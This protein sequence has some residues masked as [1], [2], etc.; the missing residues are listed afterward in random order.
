M[1]Y[2]GPPWTRTAAVRAFRGVLEATRST[3][4]RA[5]F[6]TLTTKEAQQ[7]IGLCTLQNLDR[8]S[9]ADRAGCDARAAGRE[10]GLATE[11]LI[12]VI[13][14]AFATLPVDE[15]WVRFAIDHV[16]CERLALS[17]GL[18]RYA[19]A[20][21]ED[22]AANCGA[23]RPAAAPGGPERA[24][25]ALL[26]CPRRSFP[27]RLAPEYRRAAGFPLHR[28]DIQNDGCDRFPGAARTQCPPAPRAGRGTGAGARRERHRSRAA[29]RAARRRHAAPG[30][31]ARRAADDLLPD[32]EARPAKPTKT[33]RTRRRRT[34]KR[35]AERARRSVEVPV[36]CHRLRRTGGRNASARRVALGGVGFLC[37]V[38]AS[39][40]LALSPQEADQ[41]LHRADERQ[42]R[43]PGTVQHVSAA[44]R[45][46]SPRRSRSPQQQFLQYLQGWQSAYA[47]NYAQAIPPLE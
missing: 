13:A 5:L 30:R 41:L 45:R 32:R 33:K 9:A 8:G 7:P 10:Q 1:R 4:P 19:A 43:R 2:I 11:A 22:R 16:A 46:A 14:H 23:G 21:P 40:A 20:S 27:R 34:K 31:A 17:V 6:L 44:T 12:A 42:G 3:P 26:G 39:A 24:F 35:C 25:R 38:L 36:H 47:G 29:Q 15:V 28:G 18:V 37:A